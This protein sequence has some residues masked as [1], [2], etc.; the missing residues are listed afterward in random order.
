MKRSK[1]AI[2]TVVFLVLG[3]NLQAQD[4]EYNLD[5]TYALDEM[6]PSICKV[7]ML[8]LAYVALTVQMFIW[9]Y[10]AL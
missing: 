3:I 8:K 10:T 1:L 9:L 4:H 5:E 6:G 7:T 2:L